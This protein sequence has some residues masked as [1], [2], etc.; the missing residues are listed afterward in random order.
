MRSARRDREASIVPGRRFPG[1]WDDAMGLILCIWH[2]VRKVPVPEPVGEFPACPS[3]QMGSRGVSFRTPLAPRRGRVRR[4]EG[5][6][7]E[8]LGRVRVLPPRAPSAKTAAKRPVYLVIALLLVWMVGLFGATEGCQTIDVLH[9]P[10]S[11]R[12]AL[13]R[14]NDVET[15]KRQEALIDTVLR[16]GKP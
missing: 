10:E 1:T 5:D 2:A 4:P 6:V 13:E 7:V 11:V 3:G 15:S 14:I 9:H 12:V 8:A 16:F